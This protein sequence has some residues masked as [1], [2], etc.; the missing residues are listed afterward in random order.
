MTTFCSSQK[1]ESCL[2]VLPSEFSGRPM[3]HHHNESDIQLSSDELN[4]FFLHSIAYLWHIAVVLL[5]FMCDVYMYYCLM[6]VIHMLRNIQL[7]YAIIEHNSEYARS[8]DIR[9]YRT[10]DAT[11]GD[12]VRIFQQL[13]RLMAK[14]QLL[15]RKINVC[16]LVQ[17]FFVVNSIEEDKQVPVFLSVLE[18]KLYALLRDL[19]APAKPSDK[20]FDDLSD[21]LTKHFKPKPVVIAERFHFHLRN[22]ATG[23][24]IAQYIAELHHLVTHC[25]FGGSLSEA[26]WD[27]LVC[28]L[29]N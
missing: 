29:K 25:K 15:S 2:R 22:Q 11:T 10:K 1:T 27:R 17:L 12:E 18:E 8:Q 13:W 23:E 6:F 20:N 5:E 19:L 28:G 9:R 21:V 4:C 3:Q 7:W 16:L 24:S 26:L 14:C